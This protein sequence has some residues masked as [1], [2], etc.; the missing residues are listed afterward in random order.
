VPARRLRG[1]LARLL[2]KPQISVRRDWLALFIQTLVAGGT[3]GLAVASFLQIKQAARAAAAMERTNQFS[4]AASRSLAAPQFT[5]SVQSIDS[6][7]I[8]GDTAHCWFQVQIVNLDSQPIRVVSLSC[9]VTPNDSPT[10]V[11]P[12]MDTGLVIAAHKYVAV[13]RPAAIG[14]TPSTDM[15]LTSFLHVIAAASV[16]GRAGTGFVEHVYMLNSRGHSASI[17]PSMFSREYRGFANGLE[18]ELDPRS[19][20]S[21]WRWQNLATLRGHATS[22]TGRTTGGRRDGH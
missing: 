3:I 21:I 7:R 18:V 17:Q 19:E 20:K 22:D 4:E 14:L 13:S 16:E 10:V 1:L 12:A 6:A 15:I 2:A 8:S 11:L 5:A 9:R